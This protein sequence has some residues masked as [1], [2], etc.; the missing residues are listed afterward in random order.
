MVTTFLGT[1][2]CEDRQFVNQSAGSLLVG[3]WASR[4]RSPAFWRFHC[5]RCSP[6]TAPIQPRSSWS[7]NAARL[8]RA[9]VQP[10]LVAA[11]PGRLAGCQRR[12][13]RGRDTCGSTA[14]STASSS[15]RRSWG[16]LSALLVPRP[17]TL[18]PLPDSSRG[19][20]QL[21]TACRVTTETVSPHV[22]FRETSLDVHTGVVRSGVY[23]SACVRFVLA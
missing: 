8:R 11:P 1:S 9:A 15:R 6:S 17:A 2:H 10:S 12:A 3:P 13:R 16:L 7:A 19:G 14:T 23:S 5:G 4:A 18:P 20:A 22:A 21:T